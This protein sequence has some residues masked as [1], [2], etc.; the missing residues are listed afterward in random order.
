MTGAPEPITLDDLQAFVDD[1]LESARRKEVEA[2]LAQNEE[3]RDRVADYRRQG[4]ALRDALA[5]IAEESVPAEMLEVLQDR[6]PVPSP[7]LGRVAAAFLFLAVGGALGWGFDK[8]PFFDAQEK[9]FL[10]EAVIAH[11]LYAHGDAHVVE[12]AASD[13]EHLQT[14]LS[15]RLGV[16]VMAPDLS[17]AG[18]TLLG[19]RL[20]P[21]STGPA[22]LL[23]Y[24]TEAGERVT[25]YITAQPGNLAPKKVYVEAGVTGALAWPTKSTA[26]AISA[27]PGR[28]R[29]VEI[30]GLVNSEL[31]KAGAW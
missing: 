11:E 29:L 10:Q 9:R 4:K 3:D 13:K 14:W 26:Y 22:A 28:E 12:I 8:L 7:W 19:G 17:G 2:H 23:V 1:E 5:G 6:R 18:L 31:K 16:P 27:G 15:E 20:V 25:C 21:A 24:E 30:A